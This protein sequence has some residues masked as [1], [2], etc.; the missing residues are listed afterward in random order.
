M[1]NNNDR[2]MRWCLSLQQYAFSVQY[3]K[4]TDNIGADLL[5]RCIADVDN[6]M[7]EIGNEAF[8]RQLLIQTL[9]LRLQLLKVCQSVR[10]YLPDGLHECG[11]PVCCV[12]QGV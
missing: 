4:G 2:L 3:I 7:V 10:L 12:H 8:K 1:A 11:E 9:T 6:V 5:S